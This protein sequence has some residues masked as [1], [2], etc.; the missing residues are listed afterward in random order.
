M[1]VRYNGAMRSEKSILQ[2]RYNRA[3]RSEKHPEARPADALAG[4]APNEPFCWLAGNDTL[5]IFIHGFLGSPDSFR[6]LARRLHGQ[7][8]DCAALLLPGHGGTVRAFSRVKAPEWSSHVRAEIDRLRPGYR[9]VILCGHSLGSLLALNYIAEEATA[10]AVAQPAPGPG[11]EPAGERPAGATGRPEPPIQGL[12]LFCT[13]MRLRLRPFS[14]R[15]GL[16]QFLTPPHRDDPVTA[17]YRLSYGL[18]RPLLNPLALVRPAIAL[19]QVRRL[20]RQRLAQVTTPTLIIQ[21][22]GD[23]T[24]A[25]ASARE[26][27][28][29]IGGQVHIHWLKRSRHAWTDPE[30][31]AGIDREVDRLLQTVRQGCPPNPSTLAP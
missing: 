19:I 14:L 7:G 8:M 9:Q 6:S 22:L 29:R 2:V 24:A 18:S 13:P 10:P 3:M 28:L 17:A 27:A 26:I 25:P 5:V 1:Q 15:I 21:S 12:I 16:K 4:S 31:A 23:E 11:R 20:A 30:E